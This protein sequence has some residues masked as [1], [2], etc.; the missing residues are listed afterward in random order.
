MGRKHNARVRRETQTLR[1]PLTNT[2]EN[3]RVTGRELKAAVQQFQKK[4][5]R[6]EVRQIADMRERFK[7]IF[8]AA[9]QLHDAKEPTEGAK[10]NQNFAHRFRRARSSFSST[11][12]L[13]SQHL[14]MLAGQS[15]EYVGLVW[16]AIKILLVAEVNHAK[17]RQC[18]ED[19]LIQLSKQ[20]RLIETLTVYIPTSD[21]VRALS[22]AYSSFTRFLE[23]AVKY[24]S[25]NRFSGTP[26]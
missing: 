21:M 15:P 19:Q 7:E 1:I 13:Y 9:E 20:F 3:M 4:A 17:L 22:D 14:D 16:G 18:V 11:V 6:D 5:S 23:K 10:A 26:S 24:Y 12:F 25:E 2:R 8:A